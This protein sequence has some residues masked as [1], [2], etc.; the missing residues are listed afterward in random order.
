LGAYY[1]AGRGVHEDLSQ[2]YFWSILAL[3]QGD[4][5][6]KS[7]LEGLAARMTRAQVNA[8]RQQADDWLR[9]HHAAKAAK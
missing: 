8:A 7:R 6:M 3:A 4:Q 5:A 9:Q 1:W 2:A